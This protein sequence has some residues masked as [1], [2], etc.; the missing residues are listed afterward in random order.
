MIDR[1]DR[2]L[3]PLVR[4]WSIPGLRWALGITFVWFGALKVFDVSP[5][6]DIVA[7]T[8]YFVDPDWLVPALGVFEILIGIGLLARKWLRFVLAMLFLQLVGTFLVF[9][10][11][12]EITFQDSNPLLLTTEG[13][14]IVKNLVLLAA[15]MVI[16]SQVEEDAETIP[17]KDG[18]AR[19][20]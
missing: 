2:V 5:V 20:G 8:V 6:S 1:A 19:R 13:E 17:A 12:P 9:L 10:L 7:A 4:R 16:G 3:V 11:M 14:F 15:A 18:G